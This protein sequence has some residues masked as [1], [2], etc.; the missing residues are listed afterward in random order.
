MNNYYSLPYIKSTDQAGLKYTILKK[1]RQ[2]HLWLSNLHTDLYHK[3]VYKEQ[4]LTC[5]Q[6]C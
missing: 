1:I 5:L 2:V 4:V 3:I 6:V